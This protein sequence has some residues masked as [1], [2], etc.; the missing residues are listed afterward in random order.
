MT[1]IEFILS[2]NEKLSGLPRDDVRERLNFYSEMIEDRMEEGLSE[3]EAVLAVG[4]VDEIAAQIIADIPVKNA[5][6]E[7]IRSKRSLKAWEIVLLI[8]GSPVWFSLLVA[9]FA[10]ILSLYVSVWA[11]IISLWAVFASLVACSPSGV[12]TG[13]GFVIAGKALSGVAVMSSGI[14]CA[15]LSILSF[16]GC[17]ALTK[18]TLLLTKNAALYIKKLFTRRE[19]A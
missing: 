2:L 9:A 8:L 6:K 12:A 17:K 5:D 15:G 3:E 13:V 18:A 4:S 16:Y 10:V 1:K 19:E 11:V 14:V 7:K